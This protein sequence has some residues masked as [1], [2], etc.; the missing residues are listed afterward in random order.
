MLLTDTIDYT[1][2]IAGFEGPLDLLLRL[3]EREEL[4][5]TT[6]ASAQVTDAYLAHVRGMQAPEPASLSAFLVI[7]ARLLLIKSR[8]LLPRQPAPSADGQ[9]D[10]AEQLVR[11]LQEY[12]RYKHAAAMLRAIDDR[13][14]RSYTR[15]APP[16][17]PPREPGHERLEVS[18]D[19]LIAAVQ[20]RMQLMLPLEPDTIPLPTRKILT[21]AEVGQTIQQRLRQQ[22]WFTFE[23]LL[24]LSVQRV[25]VIV[26][27]WAV[28]EMLKR[29]AIVVEQADL[30][31]AI[32]IGR[33][34]AFAQVDITELDQQE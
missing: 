16:V 8:A 19:Q 21:V 10:E 5:I 1:F 34:R 23:D 26:T 11:Q 13:G 2:Q 24:S 31:G 22:E 3:I 6:I 15:I 29:Q 32:Q 7:A 12:Q 27:L 30:F 18:L 25:E 14:L 17:L 4:D 33:G 9:P 28:L 20:Q